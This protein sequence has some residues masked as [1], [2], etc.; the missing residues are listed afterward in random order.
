MFSSIRVRLTL[1]YLLVFGSLLIIFSLYIYSVVSRDMHNRFDASL[2]RTSQSM[3]NYFSEFRDR[4][5]DADEANE[6][7]SQLKEGRES[8]AIFR[9]GQLLATNNQDVVA[10]ISSTRILE[11]SGPERKP[12]FATEPNLNKRLVVF[13]FQFQGVNY[14]SAV[15]EPLDK[16]E[17]QI[18]HVRKLFLFGLSAALLLGAVGGFLLAQ[19]SLAPMVNISEQAEH[20]SARNLSE[21]LKITNPDDELG[22]LAGVFNELLSRLDTSFGVMREFMADASHELRT[23]LTIIHGEAQVSLSRTHTENEYRQSLG[24][25]RDQ[26]KRMGNIVSDMLALA[27]ADAG[28]QHLLMEDLY[29][30]D[31]V[32]ESCHAAQALAAPKRIQ[33]SCEAPEDL[34]FHGNEELLQRM[35]VNLV[36]NAIRYTPEGGSVSV[37]LTSNSSCSQLVV[38]DTGIGI[39]P[40]SVGRVFDR[41]YRVRDVRTRANG[42]SGLGLSI[43]KLAAESHRGSV[44][45]ESTPG[46]G[47]TF[48]VTLGL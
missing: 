21:R 28:E 2:L 10:A 12:A 11:T 31:L 39:P 14:M 9:E 36:D 37:K 15:F 18:G 20:I 38:S 6:T 22:R 24:I 13:P 7:I 1:W 46:Q 4:E 25:I 47:S 19:K 29:L 26:A 34:M 48:T 45:L 17:A 44:A 27:R 41:F 5:S 32:I 33:L 40:E 43:V 16:L 3:A 8:A 35:I 23:P 42:G 30:N